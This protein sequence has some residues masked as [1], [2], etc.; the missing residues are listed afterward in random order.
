MLSLWF[1]YWISFPSKVTCITAFQNLYHFCFLY[2]LLLTLSHGSLLIQRRQKKSQSITLFY[3]FPWAPRQHLTCF[4]EIILV[5]KGFLSV[6][7]SEHLWTD[8]S[9]SVFFFF[10]KRN[11]YEKISK[12]T[13]GRY[14]GFAFLYHRINSSWRFL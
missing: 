1:Y 8:E 6:S 14:F 10:T 12:S 9:L 11:K 4:W 3:Y 2:A 13:Q 5:K 7:V